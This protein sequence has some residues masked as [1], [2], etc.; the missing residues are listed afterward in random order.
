M[1][2]N[3][4]AKTG[5][6]TVEIVKQGSYIT[7][8]SNQID[9]SENVANCLNQ[10]TL[11]SP[12][13]LENLV[14]RTTATSKY[15][16]NY[17]VRNETVLTTARRLIIEEKMTNTLCLNFASAK[18]PGG[19]FLGGSQAQEESLARSSAL[20]DSLITQQDYYDIN[21]QCGTAFYTDYM[22]YSPKVP[23]FRT[24]EG[25][26][27]S[28]PY[29][30]SILTSPAVNAGAVRKNESSKAGNILPMMLTRLNKVL[31]L[32]VH[33]GYEHLILGAWGCGVFRN[34]PGDIARL[35]ADSLLRDEWFR[36]QFKSVTFPVLDGTGHQ[37][38]IT[39]FIREFDGV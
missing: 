37:R 16:T 3:Q 35:F 24:D 30:L 14:Q 11:W 6:E 5:N 7:P 9:I 2:R 8:D 15:T 29:L 19:G 20:Y 1:T 13:D 27:L 22:I 26:L 34:D 10:T 31:D 32:A 28:E 21:R 38:I 25:T 33:L 4:R 39:P 17:D 36:N 12:E 23:V 18:K